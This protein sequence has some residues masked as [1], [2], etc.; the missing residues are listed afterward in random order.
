MF[1]LTHGGEGKAAERRAL[2]Q[3]R[4]GDPA[5]A[6]R[7]TAAEEAKTET[8]FAPPYKR[9]SST[10]STVLTNQ[11]DYPAESGKTGF[12]SKKPEKPTIKDIQLDDLKRVSSV[13]ELYRQ[14][15]AAKW[16]P[17]C[18]ANLRNFV[19]A[20]VRATRVSGDAV[21]IFVGIVRRGL[22]HH[23][24]T[25]QCRCSN[26]TVRGKRRQPAAEK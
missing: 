24:K 26:D 2:T 11:K 10:K 7:T 25:G 16:L 8:E 21:R 5:V 19:G 22:W 23:I 20:A 9:S 15:V 1:A 17:D 6:D 3:A 13:E 14:A 4:S 12:L 18:E